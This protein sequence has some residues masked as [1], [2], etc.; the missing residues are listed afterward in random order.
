MDRR[1]QLIVV[2][3]GVGVCLVMNMAAQAETPS[4]R[5]TRKSSAKAKSDM[6]KLEPKLTQVRDNEQKLLQELD[7]LMEELRAVKLRVSR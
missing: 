5:S 4:V 1:F 2:A 3:L 7:A 6:D